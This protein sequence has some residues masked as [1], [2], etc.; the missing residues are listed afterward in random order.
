MIPAQ[1]YALDISICI[2]KRY[3]HNTHELRANVE[4]DTDSQATDL[5]GRM[6]MS[7]AALYKLKSSAAMALR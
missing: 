4:R 1:A 5:G 3:A 2:S 7:H 6:N